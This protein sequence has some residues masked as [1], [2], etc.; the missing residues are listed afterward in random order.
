MEN[1]ILLL[2]TNP[3]Y[4]LSDR[5]PDVALVAVTGRLNLLR[6]ILYLI[7]FAFCCCDF[8]D[9]NLSYSFMNCVLFHYLIVV[10]A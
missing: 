8:L 1:S 4:E 6:C 5:L 9:N 3:Y 7:D 10:R 2:S